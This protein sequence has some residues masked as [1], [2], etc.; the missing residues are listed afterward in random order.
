MK[1]AEIIGPGQVEI[2]EQ[3]N[4]RAHRDLVVVQV[5]VAP[6]STEFK[7]RRAGSLTERVRH[8]AVGI[9]VDAGSSER[10]RAGDR[11]VVMP[12]YACGVHREGADR[13]DSEAWSF[14]A[15]DSGCPVVCQEVSDEDGPGGSEDDAGHGCG[16]CLAGVP[17][18]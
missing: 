1:A 13:R 16:D 5:L 11:V 9:V 8:E 2:R 14:L 4:P 7:G 12:Q 18:G 3:G 15:E 6:L 17:P 10:V